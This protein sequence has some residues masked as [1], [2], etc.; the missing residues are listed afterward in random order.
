MPQNEQTNNPPKPTNSPYQSYILRLWQ[1]NENWRARLESIGQ[2][3]ETHYFAT[4]ET[5]LSFLQ[6]NEI[7]QDDLKHVNKH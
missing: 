2:E 5:L 4:P 3:K 7:N 1:E 6:S